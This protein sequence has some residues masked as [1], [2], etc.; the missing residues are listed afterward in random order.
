MRLGG[1]I[2][3]VKIPWFFKN[4]G[5]GRLKKDYTNFLVSNGLLT[6]TGECYVQ[7][8]ASSHQETGTE[9]CD[10]PFCGRRR[11]S[12]WIYTEVP[13]KLFYRF[14]QAAFFSL[15]T[16]RSKRQKSNM[17][18]NISSPAVMKV[19]GTTANVWQT[20]NAKLGLICCWWHLISKWHKPHTAL[21]VW[22]NLLRAL[23]LAVP[24]LPLWK[25]TLFSA[26]IQT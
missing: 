11:F 9:N 8:D 1:L 10:C 15:V 12:G 13:W 3:M 24:R 22:Q 20:S 5:L 6:V 21:S 18:I 19:K 4:H 25:P 2:V 16:A 14:T 7:P 26:I 23:R 17:Q